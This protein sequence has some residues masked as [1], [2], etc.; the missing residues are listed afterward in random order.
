MKR[1]IEIDTCL[2]CPHKAHRG[3]FGKISYVPVCGKEQRKEL[4][5]T[6]EKS[7]G[8]VHAS[9]TGKIPDW[10]TL[11]PDKPPMPLLVRIGDETVG[12]FNSPRKAAKYL[13]KKHPNK[14]YSIVPVHVFFDTDYK[15]EK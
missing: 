12:I 2:V 10:C 9:P 14:S 3:E 13:T 15:E 4:P 8:I 1:K 5:Y 7:H 6:T 11:T